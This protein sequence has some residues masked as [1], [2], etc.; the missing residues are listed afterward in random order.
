[1][2]DPWVLI[3]LKSLERGKERLAETL[4]ESLR[5]E[6]IVA[7]LQ[8]LIQALLAVPIAPARVLLVTEDEA[9]WRLAQIYGIACFHPAPTEHDPLNAALA[10][11]SR[12]VAA[13]GGGEILIVHADL[14]Y[15]RAEDFRACLAAHRADDAATGQARVTLLSD[16]SGTG[17]NC[18][19]LTP[20]CAIELQFGSD[21][22]ARHGA[23]CAASGVAYREIACAGLARDIDFPA[24]FLELKRD[25]EE[26]AVVVGEQ[27]R[28]CLQA[29]VRLAGGDV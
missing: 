3:P 16:R 8:D 2:S 7:M 28:S 21:S 18:L 20:P 6:L 29:W 15:A 9:A 27:T 24:D 4:P 12:H 23:A 17:T 22:R 13:Q 5:G 14:P 11:A 26:E 25:C 10:Q 1:M 19:L